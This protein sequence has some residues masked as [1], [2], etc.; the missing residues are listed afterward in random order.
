M[1][2][3]T[4]R[5]AAEPPRASAGRQRAHDP[6]AGE[7]RLPTL[8]DA[9]AL[10]AL[11]GGE[12]AAAEVGDILRDGAAITAL[13]LTEAVDRLGR[14]YELEIERV[15]PIIDGLLEDSLE[16]VPVT[17]SHAWRAAEIRIA[18]YH[19]TSCPVSLA[20]VVLIAHAAPGQPIASSDT[21]VLRIAKREGAGVLPLPDSTGRRPD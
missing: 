15:R 20:D 12:P 14:R 6:S 8:I 2:S 13:N 21:H 5:Q 4:E 16:V 1:P 3:S 18:H 19:R 17:S 9:S 10:I 11:L 7:P